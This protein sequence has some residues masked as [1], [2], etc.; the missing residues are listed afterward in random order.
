MAWRDQLLPAS[1]RGA[2][3][4]WNETEGQ[5]GRRLAVFEFPLR[6]EPY[7]EDLGRKARR[8]PVS[9]YVLGPDYFD[10]RDALIGA[11]E[12]AGPGTLVHPYLGPL[13]VFCE[14]F[15][16][17][18]EQR[19]GG[20]CRFEMQFVESGFAA[21]PQ[22][23]TDTASAVLGQ[24]TALLAALGGAFVSTF[25]VTG[26]ASFLSTAASGLLGQFA[27]SASGLLRVPGVDFS[28]VVPAIATLSAN[29]SSLVLNP[30]S[31]PGSISGIFTAA[32]DAVLTPLV[33]PVL[34]PLTDNTSRGEDPSVPA[35]GD[36]SFGL[37]DFA[38]WGAGL[39]AVPVPTASRVQQGLNQQA[40]VDLV[41]GSAVAAA[42]QVYANTQWKSAGD[43]AAARDQITGLLDDRAAAAANAGQDQLFGAWQQLSAAVTTDLTSR[44][45]GLPNVLNYATPAGVPA[46]ALAQR[47]YTD[48]GRAAELIQRNGAPHPLFMPPSGEALSQ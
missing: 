24:V 13:V 9:G 1:F 30:A 39:P 5:G 26:R 18:E 7:V 4:F 14:S 31:I 43:A 22:S 37:A 46:L 16:F 33:P 38:T 34:P 36:P 12:D 20:L 32:A 29:A 48:P 2:P 21:A 47:L 42:A 28:A 44:G 8:Y 35:S 17:R 40:I 15:S 3:F 45:A 41:N 6:D 11:L 23:V 10:D 27:A 25:S 19:D